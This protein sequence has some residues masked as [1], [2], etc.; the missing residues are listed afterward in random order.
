M[1]AKLFLVLLVVLVTM[2]VTA[3]LPTITDEPDPN[4]SAAQPVNNQ[5]AIPVPV[6]DKA[7]PDV[8]RNIQTYPEFKLHSSC[9]STNS[10][11]HDTCL[12]QEP[13]G[14]ASSSV[15]SNSAAENEQNTH[16]YPNPKIHSACLSEDK[17]RQASCV[18]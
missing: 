2:I 6:T 17:A 14:P 1:N 4:F 18:Q 10:L 11:R 16:S 15:S 9:L 8:E 3:C 12:E 5:P 13:A 7:A